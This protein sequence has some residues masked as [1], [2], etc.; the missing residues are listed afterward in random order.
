MDKNILL[1]SPNFF[2][3]AQKISKGL[4]YKGYK[5]DWYDDRPSA[6]SI[7]KAI[8]RINKNFI[9]FYIKRYFE[10]IYKKIKDKQ[11]LKVILVSGQSLSL[12]R[13]MI[14][15]IKECQPNA[16]FVLYQWDSLKNFKYIEGFKDL[17]DRA[18]SFDND[19]VNENAYL[20]FLPLFYTN[21]YKKIGESGVKEFKYDFL[22]VGTAHPKK[23]FYVKKMSEM[24]RER[25]DKQ[26]VYFFF[27]SII[28]Y[29]YRKIFNK[30]FKDARIKEFNF[31]PV[32]ND[33]LM[34]LIK[35][36]KC[37][38]DSAQENQVG[39][40][41]RVIEAVGAKRKLITTNK[42]VVN[43]NFYC[44][45]NIYIYDGEFDF[46]N[47]FFNKEYKELNEKI[48]NQ[49]SIDVWLDVLLGQ[50]NNYE[51]FSYRC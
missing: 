22:F 18:Y 21:E 42:D 50:E 31:K 28:V 7:V 4:E 49:Y 37:I 46:S 44:P 41:I 40:T 25:F 34:D 30:E 39:L 10:K 48:Y 16:E 38:L 33:E 11:Y 19:D 1:I 51:N 12:S 23:Y 14:I 20:K 5:V 17:F 13:E 3:Y 9:N 35:N 43:Y 47:V 29:I 45:E 27:P 6:N 32:S 36:S 24:L 26:Y 2:D 8:I 15:K